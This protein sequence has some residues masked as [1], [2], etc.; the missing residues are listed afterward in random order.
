MRLLYT[1]PSPTCTGYANQGMVATWLIKHCELGVCRALTQR[2]IAE[3]R[4]PWCSLHHLPPA[5][6]IHAGNESHLPGRACFVMIPG[7]IG[8][9][10]MLL[11]NIHR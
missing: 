8:L 6:G 4:H 10:A 2:S 3:L 5:Q 7:M 1:P 9:L 11:T